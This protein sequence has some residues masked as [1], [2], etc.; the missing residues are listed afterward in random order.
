MYMLYKCSNSASKNLYA[1]DTV[2]FEAKHSFKMG[3]FQYHTKKQTT[4]VVQLDPGQSPN[5]SPEVWIK[6]KIN[7][8][9]FNTSPRIHPPHQMVDQC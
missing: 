6:D 9:T 5:P 1:G 3:K 4:D 2:D 8:V 7:K